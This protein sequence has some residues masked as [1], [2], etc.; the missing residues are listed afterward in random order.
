MQGKY[1]KL[2]VCPSLTELLT[3][4]YRNLTAISAGLLSLEFKAEKG[5]FMGS[6]W[7]EKQL[8]EIGRFLRQ[9]NSPCHYND[10]VNVF[11]ARHRPYSASC[12]RSN[13]F[14]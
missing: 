13:E 8:I 4:S 11:K 2:S 6:Y 3:A 10:Y 5:C 1:L 9:E 14:Y 7:L 12:C